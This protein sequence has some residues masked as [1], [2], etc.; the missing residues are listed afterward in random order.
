[1]CDMFMKLMLPLLIAQVRYDTAATITSSDSI[2]NVV[3]EP[4]F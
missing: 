4:V 2:P 3:A 1:M